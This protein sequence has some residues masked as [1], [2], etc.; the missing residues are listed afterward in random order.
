MHQYMQ[1]DIFGHPRGEI[2]DSD[3]H[4]RHVGQGAVGHQRIDAGAE[5][6]DHTQIGEGGKLA[7]TRLPY[8]GVVHRRRI[9]FGVGKLQHGSALADLV[10]PALPALRRPVFGTTMHQ[11]RERTLRHCQPFRST[12]TA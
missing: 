11:Q 5:I 7:R 10:E 4:Q 3:A 1:H 6:E 9:G 12:K 2:G 8:R